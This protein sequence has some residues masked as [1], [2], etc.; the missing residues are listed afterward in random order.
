MPP[1]P[2]LEENG[3][4]VSA[5]ERFLDMEEV[6]GSNPPETTKPNS[7]NGRAARLH[8]DDGSSILSFGTTGRA[9]CVSIC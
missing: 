2:H 1:H 9:D 6:G 4:V 7:S 8:R 5:V 3:L